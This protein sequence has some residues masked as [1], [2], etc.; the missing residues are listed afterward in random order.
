[1]AQDRILL[2]APRPELLHGAV[3]RSAGYQVDTTRTFEEA[4][5]V[6]QPE[7]YALILIMING[8]ESKPLGFCEELKH[9]HP[10]QLIAFGSN[11][12][13]YFGNCPDD[14]IDTRHGP[15]VLVQR[16]CRLIGPPCNPNSTGAPQFQ[17]ATR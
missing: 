14:M 1:V 17:H 16:I 15:A 6:W 11:Q 10:S 7:K 5:R 9:S 2:V 12:G 8:D 3:L 13:L 4:K